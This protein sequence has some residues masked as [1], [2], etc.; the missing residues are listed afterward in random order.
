M[1][2]LP[3]TDDR[4]RIYLMRHGHVDYF[5]RH[6]VE[7]GNIHTVTL[8]PRGRSEAEA[9]GR[10]FSHIRF[11][12]AVCSGLPRTKET[13]ETVLASV[14]N[15]PTLEIDTDLVEI[16][17]GKL[18]QA[19]SRAE[20]IRMMNVYFAPRARN[21]GAT[22]HE[23][24]EVFAEAQARAVSAIERLLGNDDW[25]TALVVAHE[26]INRLLPGA[27]PATRACAR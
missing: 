1:N 10:A 22:N 24:G 8:T 12:R 21:P 18:P 9:A 3:G 15:A 6:V 27:G 2:L 17:G 20:L 13:A 19:K 16:R 7:S 23:G 4:R 11:D 14:P 25:H 26:G 5:A